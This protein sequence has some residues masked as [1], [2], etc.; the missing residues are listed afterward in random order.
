MEAVNK[1]ELVRAFHL[2]WDNYPEM[3]RLIDRKFNIIAGNTA[4]YK[5]GGQDGVKCNTGD[6]AFHKGCQAMSALKTQETKTKSSE[7]EG[8]TWETYWIPVSDDYYVHFTNGFSAYI[9]KKTAEAA[10]D[11]Q[12]AES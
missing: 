1:E 2:M 9:A 3:V 5:V 11:R 12:S 10:A 8:V 4:F 6:P 7:V